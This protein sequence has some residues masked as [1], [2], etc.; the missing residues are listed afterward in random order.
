MTRLS[1]P[2]SYRG[3]PLCGKPGTAQLDPAGKPPVLTSGRYGHAADCPCS[4]PPM[5]GEPPP[6]HRYEW[7]P[8][9]TGPRPHVVKACCQPVHPG[10]PAYV[11]KAS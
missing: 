9:R 4:E 6:V 7:R 5:K 11:P 8:E 1:V 3:G 2:V 10:C